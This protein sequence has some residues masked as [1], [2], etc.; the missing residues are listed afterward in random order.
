MAIYHA[1]AAAEILGRADNLAR[2]AG[3]DEV[4]R[5]HQLVVYVGTRYETHRLCDPAGVIIGDVHCRH[6]PARAF[7][8]RP[9][10]AEQ[11]SA[12]FRDGHLNKEFWG[13]F[14]ALC[15]TSDHQLICERSPFGALN[16]YFA[17]VA[18][19]LIIAS[20]AALVLKAA[21]RRRAIDW[22]A[23]GRH[24]IWD[25]LSM[26]STCMAGVG[27]IRC[28]E[29]IRFE[30]KSQ[31]STSFCWDPWQFAD[32]KAAIADPAEA[33]ELVRREVHR[34]VGAAMGPEARCAIDLSGGLDSSIISAA[35]SKS[36]SELCAVT[37]FDEGSDADERGF[38]RCV[39]D[40]LQIPLGEGEPDLANVDIHRATRP[41]LPRP[42][43]RSFVQETDRVSLDLA[44]ARSMGTF[45]NGQ[46]GD[47]V[48]CHL[49]SSSPAADALRCLSLS[50]GFISTAFQVARAAQCNIWDIAWKGMKKGIRGKKHSDWFTSRDFLSADTKSLEL[51]GG[52]PWPSPQNMP[53]PGK[54][55]H[56]H[57]LYNSTYNMNGYRRSDVLKGVFPLLSQPLVETCLRIPTW[58]WIGRGRNRLIA[59]LAFEADLPRK[60]TWRVSKG[61]LGQFQM[62]L[63]RTRRT[64]IQEMLMDGLMSAA[65]ILDRTAL[66]QA[67]RDD[68][69]FQSQ[70]VG[71]I[72]RLC[73]VEA[74]CAASL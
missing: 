26:S 15:E 21:N 71:R 43:S 6:V 24:L 9:E 42:H 22:E 54:V 2:A 5:S 74:W 35:A 1:A 8:G 25:N 56:V 64:E 7:D 72:L 14:V 47:A 30:R 23:V 37:I 62:Q 73:D 63:L 51:T 67:L 20:D 33:V 58:L 69:S 11:V 29:A 49:Q 68:L 60:I 38:A 17:E 48:F 16:A 50:P 39:A 41:Q 57:A 13:S 61:G 46:G 32:S 19:T 4:F 44:S 65:G 18:G 59:R 55:E 53:L 28:G 45:L 66:D 27:E 36:K 12:A 34:C 3:L 40:H 31:L 52:L 70:H 10:S